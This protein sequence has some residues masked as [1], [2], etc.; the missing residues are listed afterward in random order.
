MTM[1]SKTADGKTAL[2]LREV[3][4]GAVL[5]L[6]LSNRPVNALSTQLR[7]ELAQALAAARDNPEVQAVVIASDTPQFSA[8]ADMAELGQSPPKTNLSAL[9]SVIENF[10]KPV[11]A[12][13]NGNAIGGGLE[14]ALAAHARVA[15]STA[16]MGLPEVNLGI[17][18]GAGG[19]QRLPRLV[20]A[21]PA[22]QIM[23]E[24]QP[25]G[26]AKALAIGLIDAV[27]ETGPQEAAI[28]MAAGLA[29]HPP[30]RTADR[31][32]GLRDPAAYRA[33]ILARRKQFASARIGAAIRIIDCV[34][35]AQLLPMDQGL[36]YESAAFDDLVNTPAARGLRHAFMA[37]RRALFA[38]A[39]LAS[40]ALPTLNLV[41]V[42][43]GG[44]RAGDVIV[45]A[46]GAGLRVM[47]VEPK[48]D[49]LVAT[50]EHI[51]ARQAA[52]VAEGRLT[53]AARDADW[54]R[55]GQSLD[56]AGLAGA[57]LILLA[58]DAAA[59]ADDANLPPM[60]TLAPLP[61]RAAAAAVA[62]IP[63]P[64]AGLAADLC[65]GNAA[66]VAVRAM[67]LAFG[68][69]LGW[70]V[71]FS[72]PGGPMDR[73]LRAAIATAITGLEAAGVD[74]STIAAALASQGVGISESAPLPPAPPETQ[75][76]LSAYLAALANMGARMITEGVARRPADVDAAAIFH[77]IV[78]RANGGPMFWADQRGLIVLRADL[79]ARA[80]TG[81]QAYAPDSL[82][83][84][85]IRDGVDFSS[86]NRK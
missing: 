29:G 51:A 57:D 47:L 64:A 9:C 6:I 32:D 44:N 39:D 65:A 67:A 46:L 17:L 16:L 48:R 68:R 18:P 31:S 22:L 53:P 58:P 4:V 62:L 56:P 43:G 80:T 15:E 36:A 63:A 11:V 5:V 33:A 73:R 42:W 61:P 77:G 82:F 8:G 78:P 81:P 35:A 60:I 30:R 20:G 13:M 12:A 40:Q 27:V 10:P 86:L 26:A 41:A 59:L 50:L 54:A 66:P 38:P 2:V 14:L 71:L 49:V 84:Q 24:S 85:L 74:R 21:G 75:D 7:T 72:G 76:V 28:A 34:E 69:S 37:E 3:Q 19:T 79:R 1:D 45:Q 55:L 83:D 70:K 52:G 25:V 23:L